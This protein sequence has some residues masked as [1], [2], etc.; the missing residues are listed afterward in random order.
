M[1]GNERI[2]KF[3]ELQNK[4]MEFED[5]SKEIG[6]SAKTL[7]SFLNRRGYKLENGKYTI[8][9]NS[10]VKQIEFQDVSKD[11]K[12]NKKGNSKNTKDKE[13]K[14]SDKKNTTKIKTQNS[15]KND[16]KAEISIKDK[17]K[18]SL[19]TKKD[20][21]I[22]MTVEDM[23]KLCEVYD[24]YMQVK[25]YKCM[26]LKKASSKKDINIESNNTDD[27]KNTSI[28]VDKKIW[29]DFER[30]CSNSQFS[31]QE[32]LTQAL[33]DFMNEYKHLL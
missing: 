10:K 30:L 27:L 12:E 32:I 17:N 5:I 3:L 7:K 8:K 2:E 11:E 18:N 33:K 16:S 9:E 22:N 31:K 23:D 1:K 25:D 20:K 21:K 28:R 13:K 6:V 24:W 4:N 26:K 29:E 14:V 19:K 15:I